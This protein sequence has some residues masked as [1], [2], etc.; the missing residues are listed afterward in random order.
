MD[1]GSAFIEILIFG[2]VAAFLILRLR[3]VL[4]RRMGHERDQTS[5]QRSAENDSS[6]SQDDKVVALP[7]IARGNDA[8]SR[9]VAEIQRADRNFDPAQFAVGARTAFELILSAYASGDRDTLRQLTDDSVYQ[10]L[11]ESMRDRESREETLESTLVRIRSADVI[12]AELRGSVALVTLK[13]M[14]EQINVIRDAEGHAISGQHGVI[15]FV[16]DIWTF[17]RD[18]GS[19]DPNWRLTEIREAEPENDSGEA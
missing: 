6:A 7:G 4:G 2:M 19:Q 13:I 3:S 18:T 10:V 15:D 12:E 9:G 8:V 16:T 5:N 1:G 17:A 11:D 14:S